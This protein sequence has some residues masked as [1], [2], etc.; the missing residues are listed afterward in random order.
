MD[1]TRNYIMVQLHYYCNDV[2][3]ITG[4]VNRWQSFL[5]F[6]LNIV[7]TAWSATFVAFAASASTKQQA[8]ASLI[9]ALVYVFQMVSLVLYEGVRAQLTHL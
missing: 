3:F 5:F 7:V 8:I 4:L 9:V 1:T 2:S 6:L